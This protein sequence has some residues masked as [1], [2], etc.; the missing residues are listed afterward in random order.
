MMEGG[1]KRT[2]KVQIFCAWGQLGAI[3]DHLSI[4]ASHCARTGTRKCYG[5]AAA[6]VSHQK[7]RA[8]EAL[9]E[10]WAI[11]ARPLLA[12]NL[13]VHL[14]NSLRV[15]CNLPIQSLH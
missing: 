8:P 1:L 6:L 5:G 7:S 11:V 10:M 15:H 4:M 2:S 14:A 12:T 9:P 13:L 3:V